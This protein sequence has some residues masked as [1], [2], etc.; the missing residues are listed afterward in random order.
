MSTSNDAREAEILVADILRMTDTVP[1]KVM[2]AGTSNTAKQFKEYATKAR[3][4]AMLKTRNLAKLRAAYA[5]I[6]PFYN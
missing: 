4:V 3:G 6:S 2:S 1:P 5:L